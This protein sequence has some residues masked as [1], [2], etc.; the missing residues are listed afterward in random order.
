MVKNDLT[1]VY[2]DGI[3]YSIETT[4]KEFEINENTNIDFVINNLSSIKRD[5]YFN[6]S[7]I[8]GYR[9]Y[10]SNNKL[11]TTF[12]QINIPN[13]Y[14]LIINSWKKKKFTQTIYFKDFNQNNIKPGNYLLQIYLEDNK[15]PI[16]SLSI[17]LK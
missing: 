17:R 4:G 12:P 15:S 13:E 1:K 5:F 7:P 2:I 10:D 3:E 8:I 16:F 14:K 9:I 11:I 6:Y